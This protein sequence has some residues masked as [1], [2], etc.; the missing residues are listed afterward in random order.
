M[1]NCGGGVTAPNRALYGCDRREPQPLECLRSGKFAKQ[2][3]GHTDPC[4]QRLD[5]LL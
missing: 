5:P 3:C 1:R 4:A 2:V